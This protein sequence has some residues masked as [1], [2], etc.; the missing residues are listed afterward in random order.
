[1]PTDL[2]AVLPAGVGIPGGTGDSQ[3]H[4]VVRELINEKAQFIGGPGLGDERING[5]YR[6]RTE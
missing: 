1:M 5:R 4:P 2:A 6:L 3:Y